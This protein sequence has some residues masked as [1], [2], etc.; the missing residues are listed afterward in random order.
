[1]NSP[2]PPTPTTIVW[3]RS[4]DDTYQ[5]HY[6]T[7]SGR[8][9]VHSNQAGDPLHGTEFLARTLLCFLI[10]RGARTD[11]R[12]EIRRLGTEP[13]VPFAII[14]NGNRALAAVCLNPKEPNF[15][16]HF[17]SKLSDVSHLVV[18]Y[19][20]EPN[21]GK[22][23]EQVLGLCAVLNGLRARRSDALQRSLDKP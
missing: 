12:L 4:A 20:V 18:P 21:P 2:T 15:G 11:F 3:V 10:G 22:I 7:V 14:H 9:L 5:L 17:G 16:R 6:D 13:K 8:F 19:R 23:S 1:M